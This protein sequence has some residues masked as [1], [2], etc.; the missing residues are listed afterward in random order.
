MTQSNHAGDAGTNDTVSTKRAKIGAAF[1]LV[2]SQ[3]LGLA[4]MLF[5]AVGPTF[6]SILFGCSDCIVDGIQHALGSYPIF[7]FICI[8]GSWSLFAFRKYAIASVVSALPLLSSPL[9]LNS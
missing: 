8:V 9:W 4:L 1:W 6:L 7:G 2:F 3:I 5:V